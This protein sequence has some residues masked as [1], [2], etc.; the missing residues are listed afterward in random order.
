MEEKEFACKRDGLTI[1]GVI[2]L[3]EAF[4]VKGKYP[5][6][7]MCHGFTGNYRSV[8]NY[9]RKFAES[10]YVAVCFD[11]CGGGTLVP[12]DP[13]HSDGRTLDMRISTE[14]ADL[15][16]VIDYVKGLSYVEAR[17]MILAGVS[18]G[19]FVAGLTAAK[20]GDDICR[21]IM[22]Y[23]ALC[24]PDHAR[25]GCLGGASYD[26]EAVPDRIDCGRSVLGK[27]FHDEV[28]GMDPF[29]ELSA[30]K[31]RVLLIQ[32][33]EDRTVDF[34]YAVK[35]KAAYEIGQ[36]HLQL[37]RNM[38]HSPDG[39]QFESIFASIRQ[40]LNE[41]EEI[42]SLRIIIT[43]MEK[44]RE[45]ETEQH[46]IYFTG[47]CE[48]SYFQGTILPG[49]CD[50]RKKHSG[51]EESVRAE[52]TLEG[53]DCEGQR[54]RLHIVNQWG[55]EDWKPVIRTDS[56]ALA[57]LNDADLTAVM[58]YGEGGPTVRIFADRVRR[59]R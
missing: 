34:S 55:N 53:L 27:G 7:I 14:T 29:L 1:R 24:I 39:R 23:P 33:L 48:N 20:R 36:C 44:S 50:V 43:H 22:I 41:R 25:R 40:F 45:E 16:V 21:L 42:L 57:W 58:E 5:A 17:R 47:Y 9:G 37:V 32:G 13:L 2:Y 19:G 31:G 15:D 26:P 46:N 35:A 11:F 18:Q 10:G 28:A 52:Y 12:E 49:G 59:E 6:V 38:G 30:Y 3:P 54:C 4:D 51:K 8:G 56:A